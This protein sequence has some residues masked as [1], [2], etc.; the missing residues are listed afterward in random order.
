MSGSIFTLDVREGVICI[1]DCDGP[2]SVTND[3]EGVLDD[4]Q[5]GGVLLDGPVIYRDSDGI[6]D[7]VR[8]AEGRFRRFGS[9]G[10]SLQRSVTSKLEAIAA[11]RLAWENSHV[12]V[13][14]ET[15]GVRPGAGVLSV[16]VVLFD[17][18]D[19]VYGEE[20]FYCTL[21]LEQQLEKGA[22]TD[23]DT[24]AW[25]NKQS[26]AIREQAFAGST[27]DV[28]A[29]LLRFRNLILE[30]PKSWLWT[31][32]PA[33]DSVILQ[34]LFRRFNV[35]WPFGYQADRDVRT[36]EDL[37]KGKINYDDP[38]LKA[39]EGQEHNALADARWQAYVTWLAFRGLG[40]QRPR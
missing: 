9:L 5:R 22:V 33:F 7:E 18:R 8:H 32:G 10:S 14:I 24:L 17:P 21:N 40:L 1:E 13:D 36:I 23:P 29:D 3:I 27:V 4:I 11:A 34:D 26:D 16:G 15:V 20:S 31:K 12:M 39:L 37:A 2:R 19:S 25:W 28:A 38:V 30:R 6:W 35:A